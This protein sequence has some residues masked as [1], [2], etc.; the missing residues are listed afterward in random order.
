MGTEPSRVHMV[1]QPD[2]PPPLWR[3]ADAT[4]QARRDGYDAAIGALFGAMQR[5]SLRG[6]SQSGWAV[7]FREDPVAFL[8]DAIDDAVRLWGPTGQLVY[9]N[10]AAEHLDLAPATEQSGVLEVVE[11]EG[12]RYERRKL[13]FRRDDAQYVLEVIH[14]AHH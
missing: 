12:R 5:L 13:T 9:C 8:I 1:D 4:N 10:L 7:S 11:R 3:P 14:E 2:A 6:P